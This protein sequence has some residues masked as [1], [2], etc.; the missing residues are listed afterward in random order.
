MRH[1]NILL[2]VCVL[3]LTACSGSSGTS[4]SA[5][6]CAQEFSNGTLTICLPDDWTLLTDADLRER[7]L[8]DEAVAAFQAQAAVSGQLP[9]VMVTR[10]TLAQALTS[11]QYGTANVQAVSVYPQYKLLDELR[12]TVNGEEAT[13]HVFT[14]QAVSG[15][16]ARRYY[17]LAAVQNGEGYTV[18]GV[19][20]VSIDTALDKTL[21]SIVRSLSFVT[22]VK[23]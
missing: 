8:P 21:R 11:D 16:P 18:T 2:P 19:A 20:P 7:G 9:T 22:A 1:W 4:G 23:E 13:L 14:A 3:A 15:E 17:Q 12:T 6:S 5:S 10:E